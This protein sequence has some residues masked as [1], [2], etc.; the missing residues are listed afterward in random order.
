M[1]LQVLENLSWY[2]LQ[3]ELVNTRLVPSQQAH[4]ISVFEAIIK[5]T[6]ISINYTG[7]VIFHLKNKGHK[8][9]LRHAE[10]IPLEILFFRSSKGGKVTVDDV[11]MWRDAFIRYLNDPETG[12]NFDI[13]SISEPQLRTLSDL[14]NELG[15][16]PDSGEMCLEFL[17]PLNFKREK[18][19][20]RTFITKE[21]F[22]NAFLR[23]IKRLFDLQ[24]EL[25]PEL[26]FHILPCYWHYTEIKHPSR[27]QNG[28]MQYIN[29]C[30]GRLYIKGNFSEIIPLLVLGTEIHAGQKLSNSYGYYLLHTNSPGY[31]DRRILNKGTII[32]V[33][34]DVFERYDVGD[35]IEKEKTSSDNPTIELN[36]ES[37]ADEIL[38][39]LI[40]DTYR[41]EPYRAFRIKK[42]K[43]GEVTVGDFRIVE[44]SSLKDLIVSQLL[45]RF[46]SEPFDRIFEESSIGFRKNISRQKAIELFE[47]AV[48]DGYY[49]VFESDIEDFFPS[50]NHETLFLLLEHYI[51]TKDTITKATLK[52]LIANDYI[53]SGR[54]YQRTKGLA[55]GSPLSPL[56]A[57]LY[58][59]TFDEQIA[60]M[61]LRL[62]RYADD[63]IIL[64][65]SRQEAEELLTRTE[66][67]LSDLG[68][69]LK[70]EKTAIR[71]VFEGFEFL[72]IRFQKGDVVVQSDEEVQTFKKPL[73]ITEPYVFI[74]LNAETIQIKKDGNIVESLPVRRLSEIITMGNAA[75][76]TS[77]IKR[78]AEQNIPIT[79]TLGSGYFITTIKPETKRHFDISYLHAKKY[80]SLSEAMRLEIAKEILRAKI[81]NYF[82]LFKN[83]RFSADN[84]VFT[85]LEKTLS[86]INGATE[87]NELRGIEGMASR[88]IFET[89]NELIDN[90][91]FHI[92][93]RRREKPDRINTLLNLAHY[94]IFSRINATLR[95]SG[96]NPYLGF[97]HEPENRYESLAADIQEVFRARTEAFIIKTVNLTIIK[98]EDFTESD[99]GFY[100]KKD[101]VKRF[102]KNL[103]VELERA[104][105]KQIPSFK[106]QIYFQVIRLKQF[107]IEDKTLT[108]YRWKG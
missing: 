72:G 28:N 9:R 104:P 55:Q 37:F 90:P 47:K 78:C 13:I 44:Q 71:N 23:R 105:K 22:L 24:I 84:P 73:Y 101:A 59:D 97:L 88:K 30:C 98:E 79:L 43:G 87:L 7:P 42:K 69:R 102:I 6:N 40:S 27:S 19:K 38:K 80:Y 45:L 82:T 89:M 21:E 31:F 1:S 49:Y 107:M 86:G 92:A 75:F 41:P 32:S 83:R 14:F 108:F 95:S 94:L 96:L 39:E 51:P 54:Q 52:K 29:G 17:T 106:D 77:L 61:D 4:P 57:N 68:L 48:N 36:E 93:Q 85:H 74:S 64:T 53:E 26:N 70:K 50:V 16:I 2:R 56:L 103:E 12:K 33:I 34:Q 25:N 99:S 60:T 100:L 35:L 58:L 15:K 76:S 46:L 10:K 3:A 18:D 8:F 63:F 11:L 81:E 20:P 62:I 65:K 5:G 66:S 67:F 91:A